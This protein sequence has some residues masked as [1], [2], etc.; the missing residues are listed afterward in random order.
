MGGEPR[1]QNEIAGEIR[2]VVWMESIAPGE[3][4]PLREKTI[5]RKKD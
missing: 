5:R 4:H 3:Y 2:F 1:L